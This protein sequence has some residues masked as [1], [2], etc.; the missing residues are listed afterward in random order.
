MHRFAHA[1]YLVTSTED[2]KLHSTLDHVPR[3]HTQTTPHEGSSDA[4]PSP[5]RT[6]PGAEPNTPDAAHP[7]PVSPTAPQEATDTHAIRVSRS[8]ESIA[9]RPRQRENAVDEAAS[10]SRQSMTRS[11]ERVSV[12]DYP[13][14]LRGVHVSTQTFAVTRHDKDVV[15]SPKRA[16]EERADGAVN[17]DDDGND[18]SCLNKRKASEV[19]GREG[20][21]KDACCRVDDGAKSKRALCRHPRSSSG[22]IT[23]SCNSLRPLWSRS[24]GSCSVVRTA[25]EANR[26]SARSYPPAL[27]ECVAS[28][29]SDARRQRG[30]LACQQ[31]CA[32]QRRRSLLQRYSPPS[33]NAS[34][35]TT[36]H[37]LAASAA[38]DAPKRVFTLNDQTR[39]GVLRNVTGTALHDK[40]NVFSAHDT[41]Q[42]LSYKTTMPPPAHGGTC[43]KET[44]THQ[45]TSHGR[46]YSKQS[47][48]TGDGDT[49]R[50]SACDTN[51]GVAETHTCAARTQPSPIKKAA[52]AMYTPRLTINSCAASHASLSSGTCA[53]P[54]TSSSH[55]SGECVVEDTVL[56]LARVRSGVDV[57]ESVLRDAAAQL[58]I[59]RQ[60][61]P[62]ARPLRSA[63]SSTSPLSVSCCHDMV[64]GSRPPAA[65]PRAPSPCGDGMRFVDAVC[66]VAAAE[67]GPWGEE[68][69]DRW[70][71]QCCATKPRPFRHMDTTGAE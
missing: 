18:N 20:T 66:D 6:Q 12:C 60:P 30:R 21:K 27:A 1:P 10:L 26:L 5:A 14:S 65:C 64:T 8:D 13:I 67:S 33:I 16:G 25:H 7:H 59:L 71:R 53:S 22:A 17:D 28:M 35:T 63:A 69:V 4:T 40:G 41:R 19:W 44:L 49:I 43:A 36:V 3:P 56:H 51:D 61:R 48:S 68:V 9:C 54:P 38:A 46:Y 62:P 23:P 42:A 47:A 29:L 39:P 2:D 45:Q 32:Q 31:R 58:S 55:P 37:G 15:V 57:C 24:G 11:P 50:R 52:A 70:L 34:R